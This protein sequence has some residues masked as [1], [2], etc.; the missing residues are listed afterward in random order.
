MTETIRDDAPLQCARCYTLNAAG[1]SFCAK[2]GG[3]L[4]PCPDTMS[5]PSSDGGRAPMPDHPLA[6]GELFAG[7]YRIVEE[8]GRGGMGR[9]YKAEDTV[10]N[11]VVAL[12]VIRP[13]LGADPGFVERF[14]REMLTARSVSHENIIRIHDL[15]EA[16]GLKFI[17]MDYIRG[18]TLWDLIRSS[19]PLAPE[20]AFPLALQI[21]EALRAFHRKGIAHLD[22]KPANIMIDGDSRVYVLDFGLA[23][24]LF[25]HQA[26]GRGPIAGTLCYMSP[27][28]AAGEKPDARSDIYSFGVILYEMFT[29]RRPFAAARIGD[30][31]A[32]VREGPPPP[33]RAANP[34][35]SPA[36]E[37]LILE[38][39]E[40]DK[41][42]RPA[43]AEALCDA[44]GKATTERETAVAAARGRKRRFA[45]AGAAGFTALAAAS[46][47]ILPLRFGGR[48][49]S[50]AVLYLNDNT[51][52]AASQP[53]G[54]MFT[55]LL[56]QDL[57]QSKYLRVLKKEKLDD[58]L[59]ALGLQA[60]RAYSSDK[61][62]LLADR[63]GVEN[64]LTGAIDKAASSYRVHVF[65]QRTSSLE[66]LGVESVEADGEAGIF[67]MVD[68]LTRKIKRRLKISRADIAL[69]IDRDI[70]SITTPSLEAYR[71]YNE[72]LR[73]FKERRFEDSNLALARAVAM[74]PGF[75]L[76]Y[77]QASV[78]H[79][80]LGEYDRAG[81]MLRKA[82]SLVDRVSEKE[83]CM[84]QGIADPTAAGAEAS[85]LRL[86]KRYPDDPD[87]NELLGA[88]YRN[89]EAWDK[90][91][92]RFVKL[93][94]VDPTSHLPALNLAFIAMA[95][96]EYAE[97]RDILRT[98][99]HLFPSA[100][101]FAYYEAESYL[102][103]GRADLA[104]AELEGAMGQSL[105]PPLP[106]LN[107][108]AH[109]AAG[110][111]RAAEGLFREAMRSPDGRIRTIARYRLG[112]LWLAAGRFRESEV[113]AAA[114]QIEAR[115]GGHENCLFDTALLKTYLAWRRSA[116]AD[117]LLAAG[118][119][120][121]AAPR[122]E[123]ARELC[124]GLLFRG[125]TFIRQD[126]LVEAGETAERIRK[127]V[128]KSGYLKLRRCHLHLKGALALAEGRLDE[129]VMDLRGAL[130]LMPAE[131]ILPDDRILC[132]DMLAT[133]LEK[134]GEPTAALETLKSLQ[135]L[136][137]GRLLW[138]D[139]YARSYYRSG[140]LL[141]EA[142]DVR[143][144]RGSYLKFLELW[145][146]A[147]PGL[148]EVEDARRRLAATAG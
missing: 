103:E 35:V 148:A 28:Q 27:E 40:K 30:A 125:L 93:A 34:L 5:L 118:E 126:K 139:V 145:K 17:S 49:I 140:V 53:M 82:L 36:L 101:E 143:A 122:T 43:S 142:G 50:L 1:A 137:L 62:R 52:D 104:M 26:A 56:T 111:D 2:C 22:L 10:L 42:R 138:G 108:L 136:A 133:V 45:L 121:E 63:T 127:T 98:N 4:E 64:I 24:A 51:G 87:G 91:G 78:N 134:L 124:R 128:E 112:Q 3:P 85:Y 71:A 102:F 58:A 90:A 72:G 107:G 81:D 14:K 146:G 130:A 20:R 47:L 69:D 18:Q 141:E 21:G 147:D 120:V 6:A 70:R 83:Y 74:D 33:L 16:R 57:A 23:R 65:L 100:G 84:I 61:I 55:D 54:R 119:A 80:Y 89:I 48:A 95:R 76:A 37:A 86:L 60:A 129:A 11:I 25:D 75:A 13:E 12:K 15:G 66:T 7:R 29:G 117:A 32:G 92:E 67:A 132:L 94:E 131:Y 105:D 68:V 123:G 79:Q 41:E 135:G 97:G 116:Y 88:L 8:I 38:C 39:L 19:A 106:P 114:A 109:Q 59:E 115:R 110:D 99:R 44:L 73:L 113:E 31:G 46:A 96:G 77:F 144:A 9:V